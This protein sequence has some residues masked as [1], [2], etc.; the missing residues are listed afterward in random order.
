MEEC[1]A[2]CHRIGIMVTGQLRCLGTSQRLKSVFGK[3]YQLD[4]I[5]QNKGVEQ[6]LSKLKEHFSNCS[7]L[8]Q[9]DK[10]IKI[11]VKCIF[12]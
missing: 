3:G 11:K 5:A 12:F 10:N 4:V 2:L 7:V 8:E 9:H 1:E 6:I